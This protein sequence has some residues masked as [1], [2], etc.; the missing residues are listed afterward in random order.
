MKP[1]LTIKERVQETL[2]E[3][4][5]SERQKILEEAITI[6]TKDRTTTHGNPEDNFA[7]IAKLWSVYLGR[8]VSSKDVAVM[9]ILQKVSRLLT[10]PNHR[11]NWIDI[12]GYAA[13]GGGIGSE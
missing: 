8:E 1:K 7:I 6:I 13:C 10:S 12:A 5:K 2:Q 11:D 3:P 4:I 9:N